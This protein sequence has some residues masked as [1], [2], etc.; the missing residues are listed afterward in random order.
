MHEAKL[1]LSIS[2]PH[3]SPCLFIST[4]FYI[5]YIP[6]HKIIITQ[7]EATGSSKSHSKLVCSRNGP[8][9]TIL[10]IKTPFL[11]AHTKG[12]SHCTRDPTRLARTVRGNTRVHLSLAYSLSAW[13]T[14]SCPFPTEP[15]HMY[16]QLKVPFFFY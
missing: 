9:L 13:F 16:Q 3:N 1:P 4:P 2:L 8:N 11:R 7:L 12:F 6:V 10:G 15:V 5:N 14:A